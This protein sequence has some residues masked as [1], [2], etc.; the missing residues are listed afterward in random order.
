MLRRQ[1]LIWET[2]DTILTINN[3]IISN[4]AIFIEETTLIEVGLVIYRGVVLREHLSVRVKVF[5]N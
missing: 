1:N 5:T 2:E 4:T 3:F